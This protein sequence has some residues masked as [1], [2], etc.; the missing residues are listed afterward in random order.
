MGL[1]NQ[2]VQVDDTFPSELHTSDGKA[3]DGKALDGK[4]LDGKHLDG[5]LSDGR[6]TEGR[7]SGKGRD[8]SNSERLAMDTDELLGLKDC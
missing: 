6:S 3:F 4:H 7:N 5:K 2:D 1:V 8:S